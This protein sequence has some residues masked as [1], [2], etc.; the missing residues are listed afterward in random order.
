MGEQ[1]EM[2]SLVVVSG[3][4]GT[5]GDGKSGTVCKSWGHCYTTEGRPGECEGGG[6]GERDEIM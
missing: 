2:G 3:E 1:E 5:R 4:R 6:G